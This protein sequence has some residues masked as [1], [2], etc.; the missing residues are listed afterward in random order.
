MSKTVVERFKIGGNTNRYPVTPSM[1][2]IKLQN[3]FSRIF[4][5]DAVNRILYV[6]TESGIKQAKVG[7]VI[8]RFSDETY[9]VEKGV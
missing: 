2:S 9:D 8:I 5:I 1:P 6:P 4:R 3:A 7:D